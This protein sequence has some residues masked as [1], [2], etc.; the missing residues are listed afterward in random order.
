MMHQHTVRMAVADLAAS[1]LTLAIDDIV[2]RFRG[3]ED[4]PHIGFEMR[5]P[6]QAS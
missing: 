6:M 5:R 2:D 1:V 4:V 3:G